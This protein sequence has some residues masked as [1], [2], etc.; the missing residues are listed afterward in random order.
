MRTRELRQLTKKELQRRLKKLTVNIWQA[1]TILKK[2][3]GI[4][5]ASAKFRENTKSLK[6]LKKEKARILTLLGERKNE[7]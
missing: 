7:L 3:Q 4:G 6:N 2:H 1:R 5:E